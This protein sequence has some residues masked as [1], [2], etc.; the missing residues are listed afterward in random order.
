MTQVMTAG[1]TEA[2]PEERGQPPAARAALTRRASGAVLPILLFGLLLLGAVQV[3]VDGDTVI[4]RA[5]EFRGLFF[6]GRQELILVVLEVDD[7]ATLLGCRIRRYREAC[8]DEIDVLHRVDP[9]HL[10]EL[11]VFL[12][13]LGVLKHLGDEG[14]SYAPVDVDGED[15]QARLR[16]KPD[17][18]LRRRATRLDARRRSAGREKHS[19]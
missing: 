2:A 19:E 14:R 13:G 17:Q 5:L 3:G 15:A 18:G 4:G 8:D 6:H 9:G 12:F 10:D 1:M 11:V 7:G 16:Q